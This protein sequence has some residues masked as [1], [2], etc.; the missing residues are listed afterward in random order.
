VLA[1][2]DVGHTDPMATLPLGVRARLDAGAQ[3][4][5]LLEA[6]TA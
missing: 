3:R 6:P 2:L 5:E 4:F 1:G